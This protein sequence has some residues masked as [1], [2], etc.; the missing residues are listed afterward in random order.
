VVIQEIIVRQLT[1]AP[2]EQME[3]HVKMGELLQEQQELAVVVVLLTTRELTVR[4]LTHVQ[5][6]LMEILVRM[7][8]QPLEP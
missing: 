5:T 4:P 6:V 2:M 8:V 3:I 7:E 1:H